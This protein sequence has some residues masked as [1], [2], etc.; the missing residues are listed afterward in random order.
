MCEK[1]YG[2]NGKNESTVAIYQYS[3][4][5]SWQHHIQCEREEKH[6]IPFSM[7]RN[8]YKSMLEPDINI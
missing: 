5:K 3:L 4:G 7:G 2:N 8:E 6:A 1:C